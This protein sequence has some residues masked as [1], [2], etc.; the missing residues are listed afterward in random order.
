MQT[1]TQ[2]NGPSFHLTLQDLPGPRKMYIPLLCQVL[3]RWR[4][5]IE[6]GTSKDWLYIPLDMTAIN[7]EVD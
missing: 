4:W 5:R 2:N 7:H 3:Q 6:L 1:F